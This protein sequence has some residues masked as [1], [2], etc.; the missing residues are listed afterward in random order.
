MCGQDIH[1]RERDIRIVGDAGNAAYPCQDV[2]FV[3]NEQAGR[4]AHSRNMDVE[5]FG[6]V[7]V[8]PHDGYRQRACRNPCDSVKGEKGIVGLIVYGYGAA[9]DVDTARQVG[10]GGISGA[11][12]GQHFSPT[13][14][15]AVWAHRLR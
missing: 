12:A 1:G 14:V 7:F 6:M 8:F 11:A 4:E 13:V 10:C 9:P 15:L 3:R 5:S 2:D